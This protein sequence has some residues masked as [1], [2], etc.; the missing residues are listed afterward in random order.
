MKYK[1]YNTIKLEFLEWD[2][3]KQ[4]LHL[5]YLGIF[6]VSYSISTL[7]IKNL[8]VPGKMSLSM[9]LSEDNKNYICNTKLSK[10]I[11]RW[12]LNR[13]QSYLK[14]YPTLFNAEFT[15]SQ[16]GLDRKKAKKNAL[17]EFNNI[18]N[19]LIDTP[20][21]V[22]GDRFEVLHEKRNY[23]ISELN[24]H[25][26]LIFAYLTGQDEYF[27][28]SLYDNCPYI[29]RL[30]EFE[31]NLEILLDL[32]DTYEFEFNAFFNDT[33][34]LYEKYSSLEN[35]SFDFKVFRFIDECINSYTS[36]LS[37]NIVSLYFFLKES[38]LISETADEFHTYLENLYK[39]NIGK[40]K[41]SNSQNLQHKKRLEKLSKR[42]LNFQ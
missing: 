1:Y 7:P 18:Y 19:R 28:V 10:E 14:Y 24:E 42:W 22:R 5:Q 37:A 2:E 30:I 31:G 27:D 21:S 36:H 26:N 29:Q 3:N 40:L 32:N 34:L 17:K 33:H 25:K 41:L 4:N 8:N 38:M 39:P 11:N 20:F 15:D 23:L 16:F 12:I 13:Y 6:N 35:P 9:E